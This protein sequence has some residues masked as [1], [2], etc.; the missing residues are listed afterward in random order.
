MCVL[1]VF[2]FTD[3]N[4]TI[5]I[6]ANLTDNTT[7]G[8]NNVARMSLKIVPVNMSTVE[9]C[10]N[11]QRICFWDSASYAVPE[12]KLNGNRVIGTLGPT[13]Y[14]KICPNLNVKYSLV[15]GKEKI[16]LQMAYIKMVVL[17]IFLFK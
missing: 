12:N 17:H 3:E 6:S 15:N 7:V 10:K 16:I 11:F 14:K 4:I 9:S 13:F 8:R 2:I 1:N 5:T